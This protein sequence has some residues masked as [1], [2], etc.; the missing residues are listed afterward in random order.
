MTHKNTLTFKFRTER[1][2]ND[3]VTFEEDKVLLSELTPKI[4]AI[5]LYHIEPKDV[6]ITYHMSYP[7]C[8]CGGKLHKHQLVEWEMDKQY[9]IYKYQY[10]CCECGKTIVTPLPAIVDKGCNYTVDIKQEIVNLYDKEHIA[11]ANSADFINEKYNLN[12]SRQTTYNYHNEKSDEYYSKKEE[13]IQEKL[14]EKN[15]EPSGYFGHDEA[16]L[17]IN[18]EKYSFL[19][20]L[21]STNQNIINDQLIP[22]KE[23]REFLETFILYS[24]KDLSAYNDPNT[25]N[26]P[27]PS[28]LPDLKKHTLTGDGLP[29]YPSI[30]KKAN[31]DFHPCIFHMVMNQRKPVW[32][33]QNR[34]KKKRQSNQSKIL[35]NKEKI[36]QYN[37]KYKGQGKIRKTDT[38]RRKHKNKTTER[39][40]ENKKLTKD[41]RVLKNEYDEFE[42]YNE[43]ISEIFKQDTI[44]DAKRRFNILNNQ[45]D[46]LPDE[47]KPFIRRLGKDLDATLSFI[48]NSNIPKTNNWLELFFKIVFPKKYRN[49]FKT[50]KGVL[51]F[52]KSR[53]QKWYTNVVL[54]E[55]ITIVRTDIWAKIE[56]KYKPII[57]A[58]ET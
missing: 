32:K 26:P 28:L 13:L 17:R 45:I 43:R 56:Q 37:E 22:E 10:R 30:A 58:T 51:R 14:E 52:L 29:E 11:Y 50:K 12:I 5:L 23:Y 38:K 35:K 40:R 4:V 16:F 9:P 42:D 24:L 1:V 39:M 57:I 18:G 53:K 20:M 36:N 48:E 54:K 47:I 3:F 21:D 41:N 44:K 2:F 15:I 49:R 27:H 34:L 8:E 55:N 6:K 46:H 7:I 19:A 31:M 25:P 33:K